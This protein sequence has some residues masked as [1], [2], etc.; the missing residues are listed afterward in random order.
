MVSI[1]QPLSGSPEFCPD[2]YPQ[3]PIET[4]PC[5]ELQTFSLAAIQSNKKDEQA[6]LLA[7][8]KDQGFFYLDVSSTTAQHLPEDAEAIGRL[9]EEFFSLSLEEKKGY[10]WGKKPYSLIG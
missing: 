2:R 7:V 3:F 5:A 9:S 4:Q 10:A 6:R 1:E 8:C